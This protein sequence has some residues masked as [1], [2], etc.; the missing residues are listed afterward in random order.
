MFV[1]RYGE[2]DTLLLLLLCTFDGMTLD[3]LSNVYNNIIGNL[4]FLKGLEGVFS[5]CEEIL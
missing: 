5:V 2:L 1:R 3:Y 4:G